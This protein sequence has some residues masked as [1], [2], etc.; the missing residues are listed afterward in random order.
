[1]LKAVV[2]KIRKVNLPFTDKTKK[3]KMND[4]LRLGKVYLDFPFP[5]F[6]TI[7]F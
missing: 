5:S 1:M 2:K 3:K 4:L 6:D 7:S